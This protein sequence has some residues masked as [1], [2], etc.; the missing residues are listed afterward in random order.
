MRIKR[1]KHPYRS[2]PHKSIKILEGV[3]LKKQEGVEFYEVVG[4]WVQLQN[5]LFVEIYGEIAGKY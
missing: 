1:R 5:C 4:P 3:L 2:A